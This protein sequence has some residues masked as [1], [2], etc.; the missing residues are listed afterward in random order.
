[1][2]LPPLRCGMTKILMRNDKD[3]RGL[4][5]RAFE[6]AEGWGVGA[7]WGVL[8]EAEGEVGGVGGG[9]GDDVG[10]EDGAGVATSLG[11]AH[12]FGD[13]GV[14]NAS[15][16][17]FGNDEEALDLAGGSGSLRVRDGGAAEGGAAGGGGA[18]EGEQEFAIG[19]G[20]GRGQGG[21]LFEVAGKVE[22]VGAGD[23]LEE[24]AVGGEELARGVDER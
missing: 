23:G 12:R 11:S 10:V 3:R 5:E 8:G 13:Q 15:F 24:V 1:M 21:D 18:G 2:Q 20:V 22:A 14:G 4:D 16:A 19:F 17:M 9:H 7:G 6:E